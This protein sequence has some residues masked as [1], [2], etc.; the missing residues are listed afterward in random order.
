MIVL[1]SLAAWLVTVATAPG[2][3]SWGVT[4][5][6]AIFTVVAWRRPDRYGP[7]LLVVL[8]VFHWILLGK[9]SL[10]TLTALAVALV[11]I[12]QAAAVADTIG[13]VR[14]LP[15][16]LLLRWAARTAAVVMTTPIVLW[17]AAV[18]PLNA[19][20]APVLMGVAL[21][22]I[23]LTAWTLTSEDRSSRRGHALPRAGEE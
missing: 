23:A 17:L 14:H 9:P 21:L 16:R 6:I 3:P 11:A 8:H 4:F 15:P 2:G 19:T 10:L 22:A 18:R 1:F 13:T 7:T 20:A 12:H 5:L